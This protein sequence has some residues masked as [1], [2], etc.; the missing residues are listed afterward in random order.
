M[1]QIVRLTDKEKVILPVTAFEA[2]KDSDGH[3]LSQRLPSEAKYIELKEWGFSKNNSLFTNV[4]L[5]HS[6]N[7]VDGQSASYYR[8]NT[9]YKKEILISDTSR[10][11]YLLVCQSG[12]L[13]EVLLNGVSVDIHYGGYTPYIIP[14]DV[15]SG[16]N[17]IKIRCNNE[18]NVNVPPVSSDFNKNNGLYDAVYLIS[19]PQVHFGVQKYG[20]KR[21]HITPSVSSESASVKVNFDICSDKKRIADLS[22]CV[23]DAEGMKIYE[24]IDRMILEGSIKKEFS[25]PINEPNLWSFEEPNLYDI[26]LTLFLNGEAIDIVSDRF[27][28]RYYEV[29]NTGNDE[30]DGFYLNGVKTLLRGV[31]YHQDLYGKASALTKDDIDADFEI[32]KELGCNFLR[33]AHYT[34]HDYVFQ[35]CDELGIIVQTEVAWVNECGVNATESY[36][37]NIKSA[38]EEMVSSFYNHPSIVFWGVFNELGNTHA[39]YPQG[40]FDADKAVEWATSLLDYGKALDPTR[41]W[42]FADDKGSG[43]FASRINNEDYFGCNYYPGWYVSANNIDNGYQVGTRCTQVRTTTGK[44][45]SVTEYGGGGTQDCHSYNPE[46]TTNC[47]SGGARHDIEYLNWLHLKAYNSILQRPWIV[48]SSLWVLFD[49]AVAARKEGYLLSVNGITTTTD[50][51]KYYINDK[52]LVTRDRTV[53]KD[54]FYLY[55]SLWSKERMVWIVSKSFSQRNTDTVSI[56][57]FSNCEH[58]E[59][60]KSGILL[61]TLNSP[62]LLIVTGKNPSGTGIPEINTYWRF[63]NVALDSS[64]TFTVKGYSGIDIFQDEI[65]LLKIN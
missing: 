27:G 13:A 17:E 41:E 32:I 29:K 36:Y 40:S 33:I 25:I 54:I 11:Y 63:D 16:N 9:Y 37:N 55:K 12:Q 45:V 15:V 57:V 60:Y 24:S 50:T 7:A 4:Q 1:K 48:F 42:G 5:P 61:Q 2:V 6:C 39:N 26:E 34:H 23:K 21:V 20:R 22:V 10:T 58:I 44:P 38:L 3:T 35:K 62:T 19:V 31:A 56:E 14:L 65:E 43:G 30:T 59:L 51:T 53:K 47:G 8:G 18:Q 52:G 28:L 49:F 64:N 46:T